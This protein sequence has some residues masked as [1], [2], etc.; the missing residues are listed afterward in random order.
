MLRDFPVIIA[1]ESV[2]SR[3]VNALAEY[4]YEV[5][6]ISQQ[7]AGISDSEVIEIALEKNEFILTED[8]DFGDQLIYRKVAVLGAMLLRLSGTSIAA[9]ITSVTTV[10][11]GH[12]S[13]LL[14]CFAVLSPHKL[15]IR[16]YGV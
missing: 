9:K 5:Y 8:K 14:G 12:E 10:F 4:G 15:R 2:D 1:D 13:E 7:N 6:S 16:K 11:A 3:I